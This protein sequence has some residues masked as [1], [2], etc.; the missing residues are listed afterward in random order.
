ASLLLRQA[1]QRTWSFLKGAAAMITGA[2]LVI[3]ILL[4]FPGTTME[5]SLYGRISHLLAYLFAPMGVTDWRLIG[6]LLPGFI[7]KE[8]VIGT[9][10]VS[11]LG[12]EPA[13]ALTLMEGLQQL[14]GGLGQALLATANAIPAMVGLPE[15]LPAEVEAPSGLT[16]V[17]ATAVGSAGALA[18]LVFLLLYTPC[19]ATVAAVKQEFGK[20][21]ASFTVFYQFAV[22]YLAGVVVYAIARHFL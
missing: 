14:A 5:E 19:V 16:A 8:V 10:G 3:W 11:F 12:A 15:F 20:K 22:A 18:Y 2:V 13:T 9:L 17:L 6:A 4:Q 7:A 21:W 1:G